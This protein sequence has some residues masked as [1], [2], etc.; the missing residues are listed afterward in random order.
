MALE[1][2]K[3]ENDILDDHE[4]PSTGLETSTGNTALAS[5]EP[6]IFT[7]LRYD[8][9]LLRSAENTK[10]SFN[11]PLPL[12]MIEFHWRR[13]QEAADSLVERPDTDVLWN[14]KAF[15]N[16]ILATIKKR[17]NG[18]PEEAIRLN[19]RISESGVVDIT[20]M[21]FKQLPLDMM[22]PTRLSTSPGIAT[23]TWTVTLDDRPTEL[24][25][26]TWHKT[27]DRSMYD[28]A[29][30]TAR[31]V[32]FTDPEEVLL[33]NPRGEIMDCSITTPY[34]YRH[35]QWVTPARVCGGQEGVTRRW[36]LA[37]G[38]CVGGVVLKDS[39]KDGEMLWLSNG[40][41]GFFPGIFSAHA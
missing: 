2:M 32:N 12:C 1:E 3:A 22:F 41:R 40:L 19:F 25:E 27:S 35:G 14:S 39:L 15:V 29:R 34:F 13:L 16:L 7:T 18:W 28:R 30:K 6:F 5:G 31:I 9:V 20:T 38:I 24:G 36:A 21:P 37:K 10:A 17:Y 33:F 23:E 26:A 11:R 8:P 4:M